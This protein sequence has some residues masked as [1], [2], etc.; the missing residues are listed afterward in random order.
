MGCI[1]TNM[2]KH[3]EK[4]YQGFTIVELLIVI[5]VIAILAAISV[6][7][8]SGI[9]ARATQATLASSL[10]NIQKKL[11]LFNVDNGRY[12]NSITDCPS[13]AA[14]NICISESEGLTYSYRY[15]PA[16]TSG[17]G[18]TVVS[19]AYEVTIMTDKRFIYHSNAEITSLNEFMRYSDIAPIIDKYGLVGYKFD[20]D[21]K[22]AD[23]TNRSTVS[24]YM[25]NGSGAKY[26][27][28]YTVPVTTSFVHQSFVVTPASWMTHLTESYLSFYGLYSTG[29]IAT[30]KNVHIELAK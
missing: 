29:N 10:D 3:Y 26:Q 14:L 4:S 24:A 11:E 25:Q 27:M 8:Y 28:G 15:R 1:I 23:T 17:Y 5:V 7:A 2:L 30:I 20:F 9:Q 21:I 12:P 16:A 18:G 6:V 13:P 19:P 22:S